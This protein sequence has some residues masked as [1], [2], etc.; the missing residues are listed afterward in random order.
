[1]VRLALIFLVTLVQNEFSSCKLS[2]LTKNRTKR[3]LKKQTELKY[4]ILY[5]FDSTFRIY[6]FFFILSLV[7]IY[8]YII[9]DSYSLIF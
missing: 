3:Y 1:M 5:N 8:S 9:M 4:D 6:E 7:F 2:D